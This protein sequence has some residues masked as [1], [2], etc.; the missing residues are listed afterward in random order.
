MPYVLQ[1][2]LKAPVSIQ[3]AF[4]FFENPYNLARITPARLGFRIT[5]PGEIHMR[6][7]AEIRYQIRV[8]GIPLAWRSRITE[9]EPP[10]RFIDEQ[11]AGPYRS[12]R[13]HHRFHPTPEGVVIS[14]E[15]KYELPFRALGRLAHRLWVAR[16]LSTIFSYR[17]SELG[18]MLAQQRRGEVSWTRPVITRASGRA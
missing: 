8:A 9:Y 17:Q 10:F 7:G 1:C 11:A 15:V 18:R 12:W 16:Q 6:K 3:E 13:H 2:E 4:E 14:D 5:S